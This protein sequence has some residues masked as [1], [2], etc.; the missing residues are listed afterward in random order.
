MIKAHPHVG[1]GV[2]QA[3]CEP[4]VSVTTAKLQRSVAYPRQGNLHH[5]T[6]FYLMN[7]TVALTSDFSPDFQPPTAFYFCVCDLT[8]KSASRPN[9]VVCHFI[10]GDD[11]K[12][13]KAVCLEESL[14]LNR[15][16]DLRAQEPLS[17]RERSNFSANLY[18]GTDRIDEASRCSPI[19]NQQCS[20]RG[21]Y[22][23]YPR[24]LPEVVIQIAVS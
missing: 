1:S 15:S 12:F 19:S 11:I 21:I 8:L 13:R 7:I 9:V 2:R 14:S 24:I 18:T 23:R 6:G 10:A 22:G 3:T 4:E 16:A 17:I 20:S 5:A